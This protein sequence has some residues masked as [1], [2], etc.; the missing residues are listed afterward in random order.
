SFDTPRPTFSNLN[1]EIY[2][3]R[4]DQAPD[5]T[6]L[7][8][9]T[10]GASEVLTSKVGPKAKQ[11]LIKYTGTLNIIKAG[12][13]TFNLNVPGGQ[14][15][16]KVNGRDALEF[17]QGYRKGT[18]EL[19]AGDVPFELVYSKYM[20]WVE[21]GLGLAIAGP[22]LREFQS[23]NSNN[24]QRNEADLI[25]VGPKEHPILRSFMDVPGYGRVTHA[26]SIGSEAKVHFTYDLD[27]GSLFQIWRGEF[28]NAT[29]MWNNR[30][31]GSSRPLGSVVRLGKP[32][33]PL[34]QLASTD[35][36]WPADTVGTAFKTLGYKINA[37][38]DVTFMYQ[39]NGAII[40]DE[41]IILEN[42]QGVKR[43]I[44]I[45]DG[46]PNTYFLLAVGNTIK[47]L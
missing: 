13:Y 9:K 36:G 28:L 47:E 33:V 23:T 26:V 7:T 34:A 35:Q 22:G 27:N 37:N 2:E 39:A 5:F 6:G 14:G 1:Y 40:N 19:P 32:M 46:Q 16:V 43:Q 25:L 41:I 8:P 4:F 29:P 24:V 3:G 17:G 42:G 30:G 20:D 44:K 15:S 45:Q 38:N 11:F 21:P 31:D 10:K 18:V 12:E